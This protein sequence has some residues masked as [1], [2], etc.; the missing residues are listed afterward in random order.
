M[1]IRAAIVRERGGRFVPGEVVLREPGP[2]EVRVE[3]KATGLCHTDLVARDQLVPF[4]LPAVL[5]HEGAGVVH[6]VGSAV[7]A[8][9]PGDHVVVSFA[10]CGEC[11]NCLQSH[12]A[13]CRKFVPLNLGGTRTD[14]TSTITQSGRAVGSNF[15]GQ[16]SF[17]NFLVAEERNVVRIDADMPFEL[18]AP[19]GC[20]IQ[21]GAGTVLNTLR[22]KAGQ[23]I[24]VFGAGAVGLA[25][26]MAAVVLRCQPIVVIDV[27]PGR[28]VLARELGATHA[29]NPKEAS[30]SEVL[31]SLG[32]M[33]FTV[34][35]AGNA[36]VGR[37][38]VE[39][40]NPGGVC[41]LVGVAPASVDL[42]VN[43]DG[44]LL[45][46]TVIGTTEGDAIPRVFI[47]ELVRLYKQG[48]LPLEKLVRSYPFE[49]INEAVA[50][51]ESGKTVKAVLTF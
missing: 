17:A 33:L 32:G 42:S 21:T 29:I 38:A 49:N 4:P 13:Y 15:F 9:R 2:T 50:D 22:P 1:D 11:L 36:A 10:S 51:S 26:V 16:S 8:L 40:L 30:V 23:P 46:R 34:E 18:A 5:G 43:L 37:S 44:M 3:V 19:L 20:G 41:A 28:L 35:A 14:G 12:P 27:V 25:A 24:A 47:P 31:G 48:H 6:S 45:G 39:C 7:T